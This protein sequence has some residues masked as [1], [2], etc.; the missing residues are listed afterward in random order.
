MFPKM[1]LVA[2]ELTKDEGWEEAFKGVT[3]LLHTASP[4]NLKKMNFV[5][6]AVA[7]TKRA[8]D[9]AT[10]AGVKNIVVTSSMAAVY[11]NNTI[12]GKRLTA[13][14]WSKCEE[15]D[16]DYESS[17]Y[18]AEKAAWEYAEADPSIV[19]NTINPGIILGPSVLGTA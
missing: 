4:F 7:G 1:E 10:K 16:T 11:F 18:F 19:M 8:L 13:A 9:F 6:I 3:H 14:V 15:G 2:C 12:N 17:K 5:A